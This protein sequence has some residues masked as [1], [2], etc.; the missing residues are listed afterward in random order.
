MRIGLG[1][2]SHRFAAGRPLVLG[3]VTIPHARGLAGHS[4]ADVVAHALTDAVL[5]AAG[6]GDLGHM[7][8]SHDPQWRD[9][10]SLELLRRAYLAVVEAG[11]D[12]VSADVTIIAEEPRLAP[13]VDAMREK[14]AA[15]LIVG[16][17]RISVKAKSNDGMGWLGRGEG[18]AAIAV[19]L[20]E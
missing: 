6:L 3:G 18:V 16:F 4:D 5:G 14:L 2:D 17:S 1:Y 13:H 8:P 15:P 12:F 7:F 19:A 20:L 10:N 9:A 11:Y